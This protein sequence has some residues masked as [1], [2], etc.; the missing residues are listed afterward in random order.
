MTAQRNIIQL[1]LKISG[2]PGGYH[3]HYHWSPSTGHKCYR[4]FTNK[5]TWNEAQKICKDQ[6][7]SRGGKAEARLARVAD[8]ETVDFLSDLMEKTIGRFEGVWLGGYRTPSNANWKWDGY[9]WAVRFD[10]WASGEPNNADGGE[11]CMMGWGGWSGSTGSWN[12]AKC[13]REVYNGQVY[14]Y[15]LGFICQIDRCYA[16]NPC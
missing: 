12:D 13:K 4:I 11:N 8:P 9:N 1:T 2:C 7:G 14:H 3:P 10:N 16:G 5:V 6:A 15:Q